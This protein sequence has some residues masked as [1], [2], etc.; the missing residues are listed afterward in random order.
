[1]DNLDPTAS[2]DTPPTLQELYN[3][4]SRMMGGS[5]ELRL[6]LAK[7]ASA[8]PKDQVKT[9]WGERKLNGQKHHQDIEYVLYND[10]GRKQCFPPDRRALTA[11][12]TTGSATVARMDAEKE[13]TQR[14]ITSNNL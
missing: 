14:A 1:M 13:A 5:M 7:M 4:Y 6:L 2:M 12:K 11:F 9:V 8:Y 10:E 3:G